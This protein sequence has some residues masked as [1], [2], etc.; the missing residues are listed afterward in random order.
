MSHLG[1]LGDVEVRTIQAPPPGPPEP[2]NERGELPPIATQ[3]DEPVLPPPGDLTLLTQNMA[4][5]EIASAGVFA[6][7]FGVDSA[8]ALLNDVG[9]PIT[10]PAT[11]HLLLT[12][13][14]T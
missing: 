3:S 6:V 1:D 5:F 4:T 12:L 10:D 14:H 8:S 13:P 9:T 2:R 11:E 7:T